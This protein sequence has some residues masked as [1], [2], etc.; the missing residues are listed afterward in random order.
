M[1][2][3]K[4]RLCYVSFEK[5]KSYASYETKLG[6]TYGV[7]STFKAPKNMSLPEV[8]MV[9]SYLSDRIEL[10]NNLEP[11]CEE[12]VIKVS[13]HLEKFGF[14]KI[15]SEGKGHY[16]R[17]YNRNALLNKCIKT[18]MLDKEKNDVVYLFTV[19]GDVKLFEKSDLNDRYFDWYIENVTTEEFKDIYKNVSKKGMAS[20]SFNLDVDELLS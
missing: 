16:H 12:S 18:G 10:K 8:C 1:N 11:A 9:V 20:K 6:Q 2:E 7:S 19:G 17:V 14:E 5:F 13:N 3:L 15:D 4:I